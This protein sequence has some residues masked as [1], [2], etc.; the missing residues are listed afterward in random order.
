M[1]LTAFLPEAYSDPKAQE[2][3]KTAKDAGTDLVALTPT[4]YMAN[5]DVQ[6]DRGRPG[7]DPE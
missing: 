4:S 3:L 7:Q 6:P 5:S 1:N 2:A